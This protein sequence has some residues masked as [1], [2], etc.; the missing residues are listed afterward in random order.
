MEKNKKTIAIVVGIIALALTCM[1]SVCGGSAIIMQFLGKDSGE[2]NEVEKYDDLEDFTEIS[3]DGI[4]EYTI[5]EGNSPA[6]EVSGADDNLEVDVSVEDSVLTVKT[7]TT[8]FSFSNIFNRYDVKI[9]ITVNY[10]EEI[11]VNG[12]AKLIY[13]NV[14][15][16]S[17]DVVMNGSGD[18][19]FEGT[20]TNLSVE[21]NGA[22]KV[23]AKDL[24]AE[25]VDVNV[26]GAGK[27]IVTVEDELDVTIDGVGSVDY[28]GDP[29]VEKSINGVGSLNKKD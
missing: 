22:G 11:E 12:V 6:V 9:E 1:C 8:G 14:N 15:Q 13:D 18:L 16:D 2:E 24:E 20:V 26:D 23:D 10:I 27:V 28:Y 25:V 29:E 5:K 19:S 21:L 7:R 17:M 3:I 4:G